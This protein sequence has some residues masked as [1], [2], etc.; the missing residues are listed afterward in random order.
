M[1]LLYLTNNE[2]A[3]ELYYWLK[4]LEDKVSIYSE[5]IDLNFVKEINP[6]MIISYN[7]NYLIKDDI[8]EYMKGKI[9]NL[10]ISLLPWNRGFSPNIWSFIDNTPKGVTIHYIDK[11]LDTGD[12]IVQKELQFDLKKE[13]FATTYNCLN[14][15]I[16]KLFQ[17]NWDSIKGNKIKPIKQKEIG[18]YHNKKQLEEL[19]SQ[20]PFS[21]DDN[22]ESFLK[23]YT[24]Y[25]ERKTYE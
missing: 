5:P 19:Q 23:K 17:E 8:I 3:M 18:S 10:H 7:Y 14:E 12:I 1:K 4:K 13:T 20:I 22:I 2:N 25:R 6:E 9:I 24:E 11:R 15:E 21:W 16:Q